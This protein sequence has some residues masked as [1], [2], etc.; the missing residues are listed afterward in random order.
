MSLIWY[1]A[2]DE[3]TKGYIEP[4]NSATKLTGIRGHTSTLG[5]FTM[6]LT[7]HSGNFKEHKLRQIPSF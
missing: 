7:N 1:T 3:E 4:T 6:K 2:L 5:E